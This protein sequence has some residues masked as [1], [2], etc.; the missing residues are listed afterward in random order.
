MPGGRVVSVGAS[1]NRSSIFRSNGTL[2]YSSIERGKAL[3][4][5]GERSRIEEHENA[6][7]PDPSRGKAS[8]DLC[9][10]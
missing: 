8:T 4:K 10:V 3:A 6:D 7:V 5:Q 2:G 1:A 9:R